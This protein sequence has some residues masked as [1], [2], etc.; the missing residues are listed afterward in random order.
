MINR[1]KSLRALFDAAPSLLA[2]LISE[3]PKDEVIIS[4]ISAN[5]ANC[6]RGFWFVATHGA[7]KY[8]H[9]GHH[10]IDHAISLGASA[11]VV[12]HDFM[13]VKA[14]GIPLLRARDSKTMLCHLVEGFYD[15]PSSAL[16]VIGITGTNGKTSSSFMLHSIL[17]NAGFVPQ[18][19]GTLGMGAPGALVSLSHTTMPPEFISANL[20][21]MRAR[22]ISH[23]IM[24][25]SSHALS[26]KRVEALKFA[27]VALTN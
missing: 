4:G 21:D 24:E 11:L 25:I 3:A 17:K 9:D 22:G 13:P 2:L 26:L 1:T 6:Q 16:K 14:Y 19:M 18:I 20:A 27:A 7:T 8:S 10:F 12:D 5:S 23:V 15:Y